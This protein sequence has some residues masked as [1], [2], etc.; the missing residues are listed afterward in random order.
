MNAE[1]VVRRGVLAIAF[2]GLLAASLTSA[3][4]SQFFTF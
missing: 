3:A 1:Q 2:A 4:E